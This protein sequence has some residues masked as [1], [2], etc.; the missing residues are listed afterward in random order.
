MRHRRTGASVIVAVNTKG[1]SGEWVRRTELAGDASTRRYARLW[2]ADGRSAILVVYP[3]SSR[4]LLARDLEVRRWCERRGLRVP[5]LYEA[6]AAAGWA[7]VEDFGDCDA[8]RT[9]A[10]TAPAG[11]AHRAKRLI[12]P[13]EVLASMDSPRLRS[14]NAPLD[15]GRLRWELAGFEL[16]FVR[17]RCGGSPSGELGRW[18]DRLATDVGGHPRRVCHRDYHLNNLFLLADGDAGVIDYQDMTL[19]PDTYDLVSLLDERQAPRLLSSAARKGLAREWAR[20][21]RATP[22]WQDRAQRASLQRGLKVIGTFARLESGGG[23]GYGGWLH[24]RCRDLTVQLDGSDAPG[25]L[26]ELLGTAGSSR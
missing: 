7:V 6:D 5:A 15:G 10:E 3:P 21:T 8:A 23:A 12:R 14:W 26:V 2:R 18:L 4:P 11:R 20:R 16:W 25:L 22:G 17:H 13:L 9:L 24:Q 1:P 19:G